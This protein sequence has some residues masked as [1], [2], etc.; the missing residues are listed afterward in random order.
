MKNRG[1]ATSIVVAVLLFLG[2]VAW[3]HDFI[4]LDGART[5]Y[6]AV[7]AN[8]QWRGAACTGTLRAGD[9]YRFRTLKPHSEVIFW[10]AGSRE[11]SGK[12]APCEIENA[13]Q[14]TCK[15]GPDSARTITHE[16]RFG[17]PVPEPKGPARAFHPVAKWKWLLLDRGATLFHEA[18]A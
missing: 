1:T 5:V 8:G 11:A 2:V 9:R 4:T 6:T 12:L 16:M 14:W 15:P 3:L 17:Q 13:K 7:C 10:V 18:D